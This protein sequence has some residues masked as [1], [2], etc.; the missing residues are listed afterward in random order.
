[1]RRIDQCIC[2][3]ALCGVWTLTTSNMVWYGAPPTPGPQ[4]L[5]PG[6]DSWI[7]RR[8]SMLRVSRPTSNTPGNKDGHLK[9]RTQG[10]EIQTLGMGNR[11]RRRKIRHEVRNIAPMCVLQRVWGETR[12]VRGTYFGGL[13]PINP[14]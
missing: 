3:I 6:G 12:L 9:I 14:L 10:V 13:S 11:A 4:S 7:G 1:M 8:L 2:D 5:R